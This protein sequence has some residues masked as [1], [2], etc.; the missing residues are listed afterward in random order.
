MIINVIQSVQQFF[1]DLLD[2]PGKI[3]GVIREP[4]YWE[5]KIEVAQ[6][7]EYMRKKAL[8]DIM[9]IYEVHL[10][11]DYQVIAFDRIAMR[12]RDSLTCFPV[13]KDEDEN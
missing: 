12:E 5:V 13:N 4:D 9:A 6:E 8:D 10:N 3:V 1:T 2:R 7:V 11:D